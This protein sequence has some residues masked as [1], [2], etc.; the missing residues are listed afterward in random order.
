M[1]RDI[2]IHLKKYICIRKLSKYFS[3]DFVFKT[4]MFIKLQFEQNYYKIK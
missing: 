2:D 3:F 1:S 4:R